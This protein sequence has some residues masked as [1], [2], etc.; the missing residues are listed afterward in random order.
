MRDGKALSLP[1]TY[2]KKKFYLVESGIMG[3]FL[4]EKERR[5]LMCKW[6]MK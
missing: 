6:K 3:A 2:I 5:N 1:F 4:F